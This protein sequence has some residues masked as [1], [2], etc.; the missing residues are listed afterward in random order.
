MAQLDF[1][2]QSAV[3]AAGST[4]TPEVNLKG[5]TLMGFIFPV[6]FE[7]ATITLKA[8]LKRDFS[9]GGH[10]GPY[11]VIDPTTGSAI[12]IYTGGSGGTFVPITPSD[13]TALQ[14]FT[15]VSASVATG[16]REIIV[17]AR[18]AA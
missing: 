16:N 4:E 11:S 9:T 1:I 2:Y 3:L 15:I 5:N 17:V 8:R 14:Y 10:T 13:L 7:G 18:P 6:G 12:T